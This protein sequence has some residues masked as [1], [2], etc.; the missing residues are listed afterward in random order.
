MTDVTLAGSRIRQRR[1]AQARRQADLAAE[2]GISPSYLNLIE[3]NRRR[4]GGKLLQALAQSLDV[5]PTL[6]S[7]GAEV[8]VIAQLGDVAERFGERADPAE[9]ADFAA[10]FP[11]WANLLIRAARRI[12]TLERNVETLTDRLTHD[13]H[14]ATTLHE[15]LSTVTAIRAAA[16]ILSDDAEIAPE[17]RDRF[18]RN[19]NE[20]ATR[21]AEGAEALAGFLDGAGDTQSEMGSPQEELAAFLDAAD[22]HFPALETGQADP[23]DCVAGAAQLRSASAQTLATDYLARYAADAVA[24]P[25]DALRAALAQTGP[26][27]LALAHRFGTDAATVMRRLATLPE[28]GLGLVVCDASGT[29][30]LR[31]PADGFPLPRFGAACPRWPLFAALGRP[32]VPLARRTAQPARGG[33]PEPMFDCYAIAVP[34]AADHYDADPLLEATMLIAPV[35][36]LADMSAVQRIGASCR[37]CPRDGCPARREPSIMSAAL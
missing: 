7:Q 8:S 32:M 11:D 12:D 19:I 28:L 4:I 15:V 16:A 10:R 24:L 25:L 23:A 29:M 2:V 22:W 5:E 18:H 1:M 35:D 30:L 27:P 26:D 6:L 37:I 20:D 36:A 17:W 31:K 14:L 33:G 13:P 34:R 3:H 9:A 21:L